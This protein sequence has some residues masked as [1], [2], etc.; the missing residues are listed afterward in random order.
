MPVGNV[1]ELAAREGGANELLNISFEHRSHTFR[2]TDSQPDSCEDVACCCGSCARIV[3]GKQC[4]E[5][6]KWG[7]R[8]LRAT[9][10]ALRCD[11]W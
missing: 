5:I 11:A 3:S 2:S 9:G 6:R 4:T 7:L 8:S 1:N 10:G